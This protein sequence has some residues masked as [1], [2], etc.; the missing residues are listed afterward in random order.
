MHS[1]PRLPACVASPTQLAL[2]YP[3]DAAFD[4]QLPVAAVCTFGRM[5]VPIVHSQPAPPAAGGGVQLYCW[6][7]AD[8]AA[9]LAAA[10]GGGG[11]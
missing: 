3:A 2:D 11:V 8:E 7:P 5:V 10:V 4:G 6:L 9:E 1:S